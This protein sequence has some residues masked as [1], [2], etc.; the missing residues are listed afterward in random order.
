MSKPP[1]FRVTDFSS[2]N[3]PTQ[4]GRSRSSLR[5][6][7][8]SKTFGRRKESNTGEG[9]SFGCQCSE[10]GDDSNSVEE[11]VKRVQKISTNLLRVVLLGPISGRLLGIE[12]V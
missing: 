5:E 10:T 4:K 7:K 11:T 2:I 1:L 6:W 9:R 3:T 12:L 8:R